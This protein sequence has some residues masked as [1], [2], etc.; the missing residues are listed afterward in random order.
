MAKH[1]LCVSGTKVFQAILK[2]EEEQWMVLPYE[3]ANFTPL[4]L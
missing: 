4:D 2:D 3:P 1:G